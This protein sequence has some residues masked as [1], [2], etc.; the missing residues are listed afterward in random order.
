M[1]GGG[2]ENQSKQH[3]ESANTAWSRST[4]QAQNT[5]MNQSF[6]TGTPQAIIDTIMSQLGGVQGVSS[7][8]GGM[9][10]SALKGQGSAGNIPIIQQAVERSKQATSQTLAGTSDDLARSGLAGT[11]FG[12][13]IMA[14][15]QQQGNQAAART[16]TDLLSQLIAQV[17]AFLAQNAGV[18]NA[19]T[20]IQGPSGSMGAAQGTSAGQSASGAEGYSLGSGSSKSQN[21]S[22]GMGSGGGGKSSQ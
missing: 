21:M 1:G 11:P 22:G 6:A 12:Q 5:A 19:L 8:Y 13:A 15:T 7:G 20:G 9:L 18:I 3:Q 14:Q 4:N 16:E 17:P 10:E 2:G